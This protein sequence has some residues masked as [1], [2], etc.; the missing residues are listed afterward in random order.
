MKIYCRAAVIVYFLTITIH[1]LFP[2]ESYSG[3]HADATIKDIMIIAWE[4]LAILLML[5]W[6][7][8]TFYHW[9]NAKFETPKLRKT[10]LVSLIIGSFLYMIGHLAY[11]FLIIES[12]KGI[13]ANT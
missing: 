4:W 3:A 8:Y 6:W 13:E 12:E 10:W 9:K 11:Y 7:G 2:Y 5:G 1:L